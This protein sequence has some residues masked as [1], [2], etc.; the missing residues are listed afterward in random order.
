MNLDPEV[1]LTRK[2]KLGFAPRR[3]GAKPKRLPD[4]EPGSFLPLVH[5]P[6]CSFFASWRLGASVTSQ[7]GFN[8]CSAIEP[9]MNA[10][11]RRWGR[12]GL[13]P[14]SEVELRAETQ[15]RKA[16]EVAPGGSGLN[17]PSLQVESLSTL[18]LRVFA[19]WREVHFGFNGRFED[20]YR[21][22]KPGFTATTKR[23][24][25]RRFDPEA[26]RACAG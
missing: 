14:E 12:S 16:E 22:P 13:N 5:I 4:N 11:E 6:S 2:P 18:R 10:E 19:S 21:F 3:K 24:A 7:L 9:Q 25:F 15:R 8:P 23:A 20:D 17:V 26:G 1:V